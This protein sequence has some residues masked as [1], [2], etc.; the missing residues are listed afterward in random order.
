MKRTPEVLDVWFDSGAMPFGQT[1]Y[2]FEN[3]EW[4]EGGNFPCDFIAEYTPQTRGWFHKL[5][6]L[7]T[8]IFN[9]PAF[10]NCICHGTILAKD[11]KK[12]SKSKKNYT[13]PQI[14]LNEYGA[15]A[16][17]LYLLQSGLSIGD[18]LRFNDDEIID[19]VKKVLLPLWNS[20]SFFVTY[21]NLDNI[22]VSDLQTTTKELSKLNNPLDQW[23][24]SVLQTLLQEVNTAMEEYQLTMAT[25]KIFHFIDSLTNWY[26][27][28]SRRR[29]W[30]SESDQD[31]LQ[32]YQTLYFVLTEVSKIMAP[33]APFI[34]EEIYRNLT[35][36]ESVHLENWSAANKQF[37]NQQL[38]QE[39]QEV[40]DIISIGLGIRANQNIKV[41]Q[42]LP[43]V[44]FNTT[45]KDEYLAVIKEELNVK[46]IALVDNVD[47]LAKIVVLPNAKILGPQYG[48]NVQFIIK[49]A[50]AGNFTNLDNGE[51]EVNIDQPDLK[52]VTLKSEEFEVRYEPKEDLTVEA[53]GNI[54][55]AL[56][57]NITPELKKEGEVRDLVR[58]IQDLRKQ[59]DYNLDDRIKLQIEVVTGNFSL[60]DAG[61]KYL[62][63][64]T[65]S[66]V[67]ENLEQF[68]T[69]NEVEIGDSK[70][71]IKL[72]R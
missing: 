18:N 38:E 23:I 62:G 69:E 22:K 14:L 56:D 33:F 55:V 24:I 57:T 52:S 72:K 25:R 66:T 48:K 26:I 46:E 36:Q 40:R 29:F 58:I 60:D 19:I 12:I 68:D 44:K 31:K 37:I 10:N 3:K 45:V 20:Y 51:I 63:N 15:D 5:H 21:A 65:L 61:K 70:L 50:K 53:K 47:N 28:R 41:R 34:S 35:D 39:I 8:L 42:P 64:E 1:H 11:G 2:P 7:G 17:R 59:A 67:T 27:R 71:N 9:K 16:F 6:V 13:D 4:L 32:A 30:K 54:V 43:Q 49:N